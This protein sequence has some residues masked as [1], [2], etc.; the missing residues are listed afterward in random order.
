MP[1]DIEIA[2]DFQRFC[3]CL[4]RRLYKKNLHFI[5]MPGGVSTI[6]TGLFA[7]WD[8]LLRRVHRPVSMSYLRLQPNIATFKV[9][10][11]SHAKTSVFFPYHIDSQVPENGKFKIRFRAQGFFTISIIFQ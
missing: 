1:N 10:A 9:L 6:L 3:C 5:E 4:T 8:F 7:H 11:I 2:C